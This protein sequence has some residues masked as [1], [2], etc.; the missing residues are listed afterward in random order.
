MNKEILKNVT[1]EAC[2]STSPME[3]IRLLDA[4]EVRSNKCP[5]C[6]TLYHL[7]KNCGFKVCQNCNSIFKVWG[8][9]VYIIHNNDNITD[10]NQMILNIKK[11][12]I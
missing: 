11:R 12:N 7:E 9:N 8:N 3:K 4:A 10:V 5:I 2:F 1:C 6:K